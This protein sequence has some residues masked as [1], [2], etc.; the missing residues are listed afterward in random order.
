VKAIVDTNVIAYHLL[1]TPAFVEEARAF[2]RSAGELLAPASWAAELANVVC[3]AIREG[4]LPRE[5]G[6]RRLYLAGRLQV[7]S[8]PVRLLWQGAL[9]LAIESRLAAYDTLFVELAARRGL[10]LITFDRKLLHTFPHL[11][12][13]PADFAKR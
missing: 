11:A 8:V 5:E 1:G 13:R 12:R 7:R 2:L 6:A 9:A 3:I 10:P 4:V